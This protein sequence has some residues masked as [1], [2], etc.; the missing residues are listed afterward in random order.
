MKSNNLLSWFIYFLFFF[1]LLI[2]FQSAYFSSIHP[3]SSE[4]VQPHYAA[5]PSF[6]YDIK[7]FLQKVSS[8]VNK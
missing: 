6:S 7:S 8:F 2:I 3:F 4:Q 5:F 1:H